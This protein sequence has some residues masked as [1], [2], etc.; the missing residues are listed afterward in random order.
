MNRRYW[1]NRVPSS[2]RQAMEWCMEYA[3]QVHNLSVEGIAAEMGL[4][5]Y[6]NLYKWLQSGRMPAVMIPNY[7]RTCGIDFVSRWL[8]STRGRMVIQIPTGKACGV[9]E[10]LL[11]QGE[12][13]GAIKALLDFHSG[14]LEA[15]ETLSQ[16]QAAMQGL[17]YHHRNVER[18]QTPELPLGIPDMEEDQ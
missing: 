13:Q 11:L 17:A 9:E 8:A 6:W 16:L 18:H 2:L 3:R 14:K 1:K 12:I 15:P 5:N 10:V 4:A 7:E